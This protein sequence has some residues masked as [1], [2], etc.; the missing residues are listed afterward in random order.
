MTN[1][2]EIRIE[3]M[4]AATLRRVWWVSGAIEGMLEW[5]LD[6]AGWG[7]VFGTEQARFNGETAWKDLAFGHGLVSWL[8]FTLET[9]DGPLPVRIERYL[10]SRQVVALRV[11]VEGI[12]VY[13]E[14][15]R[16]FLSPDPP[17]LPIPAGPPTVSA[18]ELPVP[19]D[20]VL[21]APSSRDLR[22]P[23]P[24]LADKLRLVGALG[25]LVLAAAPFVGF[26]MDCQRAY[27][28]TELV[29]MAAMGNVAE[30]R[31]RL[32]R[33]SPANACHLEGSS[34]F[35]WAV[36]GGSLETVLLLLEHGADVN[37][38]G[39]FNTVIEEALV[40]IDHKD[41][42]P[43]KAIA[44]ALLDRASQIRDPKQLAILREA[45]TG[46]YFCQ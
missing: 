15:D 10:R 26:Y 36:N 9:P 12:P 20:G 3:L 7:R 2:P 35:W 17:G 13:V 33:G 39:Q 31:A 23:S 1:E 24:S 25:A 21:D 44:M 29:R 18:A 46:V 16:A 38:R 19:T 5:T 34:A 43:G 41:G 30:V 40:N 28:D 14:G 8:D 32:E 6:H 42:R 37:S 45:V 4:E 27:G 22:P 11:S